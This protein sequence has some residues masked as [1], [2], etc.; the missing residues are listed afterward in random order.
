MK[1]IRYA[2]IGCGRISPNHVAAVQQHSE[3]LE[4]CGLCDLVLERAEALRE[5]FGLTDTKVYASYE[6][7]LCTEKPELCAIGYLQ[8]AK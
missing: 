5:Q 4:L 6:E 3:E 2:L 1:K 8:E 7:L